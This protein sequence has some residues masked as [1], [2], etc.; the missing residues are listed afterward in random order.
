MTSMSATGAKYREIEIQV[1]AKARQGKCYINTMKTFGVLAIITTVVL[2]IILA[3][4]ASGKLPMTG[5]LLGV[6]AALIAVGILAVIGIFKANCWLT[7]RLQKN[8]ADEY[9]ILDSAKDLEERLAA[10]DNLSKPYA[11][12]KQAF[13]DEQVEELLEAGKALYHSIEVSL[14]IMQKHGAPFSAFLN[15]YLSL[16]NTLN[17]IARERDI[18]FSID[19]SSE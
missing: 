19:S 13:N 5:T 10:F 16:P 6:N 15:L 2:V 17:G 7:Q 8:L 9:E 4:G 12:N 14:P 3:L 1:E 11:A 18:N